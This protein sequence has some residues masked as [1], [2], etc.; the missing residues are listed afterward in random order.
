LTVTTRRTA[1][2]AA[3]L[4]ALDVDTHHWDTATIT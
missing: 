3:I 4:A 2:Q 1:L